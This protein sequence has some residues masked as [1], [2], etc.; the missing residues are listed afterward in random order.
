M[1][2]L[3]ASAA[4]LVLL[5][6]CVGDTEPSG[7]LAL[8]TWGGDN[9]A[10]MVSDTMHVHIGCTYGNAPRPSLTL[11]RF[12]IAGRYNITAYPVD[13]GIFHP[14]TFVG[15]VSGND[16]T[17]TVTLTDTAVTLGPVVVRLG[18]EPRMGPCPICRPGS[19]GVDLAAEDLP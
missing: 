12:E 4:L 15:H 14:A 6:S 17:L 10:A 16:L 5:A 1:M 19:F 2:R 3:L 11:G 13:Q 9:A 7:D 18:Q 8:G